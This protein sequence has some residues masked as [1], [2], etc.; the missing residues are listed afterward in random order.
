[1]QIV[2]HIWRLLLAVTY[3]MVTCTFSLRSETSS[4]SPA[5]YGHLYI[6][7]QIR[8]VLSFT[9]TLYSTVKSFNI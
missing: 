4:I 6:Q 2:Q 9:R 1:M 8:D 5:H 7:P 3:I